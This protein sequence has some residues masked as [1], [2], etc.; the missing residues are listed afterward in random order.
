MTQIPPPP[1]PRQSAPP[2]STP[3]IATGGPGLAIAALV[4]GLVSAIPFLGVLT[5]LAGLVL[6]IIALATRR[7][8]KGMAA[9]GVVLSI[10]L[11]AAV[12][13]A[14]LIPAISKAKTAARQ[15]I[16][17]TNLH[18][19]GRGVA[20]YMMDFNDAMPANLSVLVDQH[21]MGTADAL[22][23][24][25]AG[26][27]APN[28][29][30]YAPLAEPDAVAFPGDVIIACDRTPI[31]QGKRCVLYLDGHTQALEESDFQ[32]ELAQPHNAEFAK[33]L[34]ASEGP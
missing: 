14:I 10:L 29:Y 13:T 18:A 19:I 33:A 22:Q 3:G 32:A 15:T 24:P 12:H 8:G 20:I 25:E 21:Y 6:G 9:A 31:H 7:R 2:I 27:N 26:E 23:C 4:L 34:Q 1:P 5:G 28:G 16:C 17:Q 11:P 30:F